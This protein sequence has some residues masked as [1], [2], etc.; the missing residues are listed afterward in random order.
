MSQ[1]RS[2]FPIGNP[3]MHACMLSHFSHVQ[4]CA[5]AWTAAHQAPLSM[6]FSRQEYWSGRQT[7]TPIISKHQQITPPLPLE[8]PYPGHTPLLPMT[9]SCNPQLCV[10][11][12]S[13]SLN[14]PV[15]LL[16]PQLPTMGIPS[17]LLLC[18]PSCSAPG[19]PLK[20]SESSSGP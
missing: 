10:R 9:F 1:L 3:C 2:E 4:L 19:S 16:C 17:P 12:L 11:S 14:C 5:T 13:S 8:S 7:Y 18:I 15:A 20:L 6:G